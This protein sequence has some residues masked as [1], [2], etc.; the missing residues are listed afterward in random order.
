MHFSNP[1]TDIK[2]VYLCYA[3]AKIGLFEGYMPKIDPNAPFGP[4]FMSTK[5]TNKYTRDPDLYQNRRP[6]K[7]N[8]KEGEILD[9][10]EV[11]VTGG[12]YGGS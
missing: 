11:P 6:R 2:M 7:K 4:I 1:Q 8:S 10:S 3:I 9:S 5:S 12:K